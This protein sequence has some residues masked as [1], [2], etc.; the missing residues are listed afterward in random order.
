MVADNAGLGFLSVLFITL[1]KRVGQQHGTLYRRVGRAGQDDYGYGRRLLGKTLSVGDW[2]VTDDKK[3]G[4]VTGIQVEDNSGGLPTAVLLYDRFVRLK[5]RLIILPSREDEQA[6]PSPSDGSL[7]AH[8]DVTVVDRVDS[9]PGWCDI[10]VG[11]DGMVLLSDQVIRLVGVFCSVDDSGVARE[12]FVTS[13]DWS[14]YLVQVWPGD[15]LPVL[16]CRMVPLLDHE[17][18]VGGRSR[19]ARQMQVGDVV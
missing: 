2:V 14:D 11:S 8:F 13:P 3:L 17:Q 9:V 7:V 19:I 5:N 1:V 6:L 12:W 4:T 16:S 18:G 15:L 10:P